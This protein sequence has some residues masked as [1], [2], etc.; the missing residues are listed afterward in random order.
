MGPTN[1]AAIHCNVD[2]VHQNG[3]VQLR[4]R[5]VSAVEIDGNY[6]LDIRKDTPVLR[7]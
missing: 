1:V 2:V 5:V 3:F 4:G 6:R 7:C